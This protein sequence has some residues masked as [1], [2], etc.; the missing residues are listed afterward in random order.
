MH[1]WS[2]L[3]AYCLTEHVLEDP[4]GLV[5]AMLIFLR[6]QRNV[7]CLQAR[8]N[9]VS[10]L[11]HDYYMILEANWRWICVYG[12]RVCELHN[13]RYMAITLTF[14]IDFYHMDEKGHITP[15]TGRIYWIT[16]DSQFIR[17]VGKRIK[18]NKS[19][20]LLYIHKYY[21]HNWINCE[22]KC[23]QTTDGLTTVNYTVEHR[24][25]NQQY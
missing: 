15:I 25:L 16:D 18:Y 13:N 1:G 23:P 5:E 9:P 10:Y 22:R 21:K 24:T 8:P 3:P 7:V 11:S 14:G 17:D 6:V 2:D 20:T 4:L 19:Y 12:A